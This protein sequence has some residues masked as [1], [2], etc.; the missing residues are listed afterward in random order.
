[1]RRS[2]AV[3]AAVWMLLSVQV[4]A[5]Q[6]PVAKKPRPPKVVVAVDTDRPDALYKKG[7]EVRFLIT[8][9]KGKEPITTGQAS[10][11]LD[12]DGLNPQGK[13]IVELGDKPAVVVGKLDTPGFLACRVLYKVGPKRAV[14]GVAAAGISPLEIQP[15]MPAPDDFDAFWAAQKAKLAKVPM[16]PKLTPFKQGNAKVECFDVQLKC[17]GGAPVSGYYARPTGAKPKSCPAIL[18]V[19]GAGVRSSGSWGPRGDAARGRVSMDIN[20]HGIPNGK[21]AA[22][23]LELRKGK[24]RGYPH[25]GKDSR[26]KCY[27]LGMYL[28]LVRAIDFLTAQPEWDGKVV[29]VTGSSQGGGQSLVAGGIDSRVTCIAASVPAMCDHSG[30]VIGRINGWPKLVPTGKDG[31]PDPKVLAAARYFDAV[32]F[33]ARCKADAMVSSGFIDRT[34]PP[35]TNYAAY[36]QLKGK[37]KEVVNEPHMGHSS[38]PGIRKAFAR[39]IADHIT[40]SRAAK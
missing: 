17:L 10:Y 12:I 3:A 6:K 29:V 7:E 18:H 15:S 13:G 34:C 21:P 22:Y 32:N 8:V 19:H 36:N 9:T 1:M 4:L 30:R 11:V 24:L 27:F 25:F 33:A 39:F 37:I 5:A 23:Y 31:K 26:E 38:S 2:L 28:R 14:R 35:S 16:E 40:R 20:A